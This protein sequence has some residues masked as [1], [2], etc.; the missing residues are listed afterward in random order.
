MLP[1]VMWLL[2]LLFIDKWHYRKIF[3]LNYCPAPHPFPPRPAFPHLRRA[4]AVHAPTFA[5][6]VASASLTRRGTC[7][8]QLGG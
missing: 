3:L 5:S 6:P 7:S 8:D 2:R 1:L 4:V